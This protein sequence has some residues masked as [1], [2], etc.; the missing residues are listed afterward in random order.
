MSNE[1][2][3]DCLYQLQ[4]ALN[5]FR[6]YDG[7]VKAAAKVQGQFPEDIRE[8]VEWLYDD[9]EREVFPRHIAEF[10]GEG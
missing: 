9:G 7:A 1:E 5:R 4:T 6:E 8:F 2:L 3:N 10:F